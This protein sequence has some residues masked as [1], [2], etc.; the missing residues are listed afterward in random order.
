MAT[1]FVE[2]AIYSPD[3]IV[4]SIVGL[5]VAALD[6]YD[7]GNSMLFEVL[8]SRDQCPIDELSLGKIVRRI[9]VGQY[10]IQDAPF[11]SVT[12]DK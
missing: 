3:G 12:I 4:E 2:L 11:P 8:T 5:P 7:T 6:G 10:E 1:E 9:G